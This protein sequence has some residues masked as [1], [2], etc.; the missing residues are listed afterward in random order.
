MQYVKCLV[1]LVTDYIIPRVNESFPNV[2]PGSV[3]IV[4]YV[5]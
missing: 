3:R 5:C 4:S 2:L 1:G